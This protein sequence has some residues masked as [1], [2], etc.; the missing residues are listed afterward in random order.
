M[1]CIRYD[2]TKG[3]TLYSISRRFGVPIHAIIKANPFVN[4]YSLADGDTI[5][6][7]VVASGKQHTNFTTYLVRDGDTLGSILDKN[8]ISLSDLLEHNA[9]DDIHLAPGSTLKVPI[10]P[11]KESGVTL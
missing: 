1:Y 8:D 11:G 7:P 9:L 2:V 3:D 6:I 10:N 4:I 5:D